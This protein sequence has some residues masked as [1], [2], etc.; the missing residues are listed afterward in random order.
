MN[1]LWIVLGI[2]CV[3]AVGAVQAT[4]LTGH[5]KP[6]WSQLPDMDQGTDWTSMHRANGPVVVDDFQSDGR[7]IV[8]FHWWGSYFQDDPLLQLGQERQVSFEI[9]LHTDCPAGNPAND[10][11]CNNPDTGDPYNYSTPN[12][13][14]QSSIVDAEEDFFGVIKDATGAVVETVYEYW[15]LLPNAWEEIAGD[16]YWVDIAWVAGQFNTDPD[17]D[18]WGWHE[19][20][21]HWGDDA[22]QTNPPS[23]GGNP[24]KGP[25]TALTHADGTTV[26]MAF[27]VITVPE[28]TSLA[29]M[30]LGLAGLSFRRR[31]RKAEI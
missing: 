14:Y 5:Y 11:N 24:H 21:Q 17:A 25:W 9:S 4:P 20:D 1:R 29:L 30:G 28:P 26:D 19:S 18:V 15:A 12:Q 31:N 16:I 27:E 2:I 6:K 7:P 22:V 8:G 13:P 3:M 10:P 23:P